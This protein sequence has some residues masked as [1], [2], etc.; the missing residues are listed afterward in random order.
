[1]KKPLDYIG[2]APNYRA[3]LIDLIEDKISQHIKE[4]RMY[5]EPVDVKQNN[6]GEDEE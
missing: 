2:R 1:L 4:S 6:E 5:R 3:G